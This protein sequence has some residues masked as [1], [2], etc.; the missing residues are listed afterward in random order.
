MRILKA[1]MELNSAQPGKI[2]SLLRK[3]HPDLKGVKITILGLA[4]KPGTND[5]RESPA[6]PIV[7]ELL[8]HKAVVK[9]YDPVAEEEEESVGAESVAFAQTLSE[10]VSDAEVVVILT[11]WPEFE[12]LPRLFTTLATQPLLID[13]RR[14]LERNSVSRYDGIG[15]SDSEKQIAAVRKKNGR[16][17]GLGLSVMALIHNVCLYTMSDAALFAA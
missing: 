4:F 9:A 1:V 6:I 3:H 16:Q 2:L 15:F 10:A 14:M 8:A 11:R 17:G 5:M 7:K 12:A 13:G